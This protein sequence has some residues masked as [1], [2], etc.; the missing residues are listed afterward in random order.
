MDYNAGWQRK[1]Y[2]RAGSYIVRPTGLLHSIYHGN[3]SLQI[4]AYGS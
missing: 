2:E 4:L 3:T 1:R